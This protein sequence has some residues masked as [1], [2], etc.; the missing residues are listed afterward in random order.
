MGLD[1]RSGQQAHPH[2]RGHADVDVPPAPG[3]SG[4]HHERDQRADHQDRLQ[5]LAEQDEKRLTEERQW[6]QGVSHRALRPLQRRGE[7]GADLPQRRRRGGRAPARLVSDPGKGRL[8]LR[9]QRGVLYS[10]VPLHLL[11]HD[12]PVHRD[13]AGVLSLALLGQGVGRVEQLAH[14]DEDRPI[15]PSAGQ[16]LFRQDHAHRGDPREV[17]PSA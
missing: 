12:V 9:D 5:A 10:Q 15:V 2:R 17:G 3:G 16:G 1:G 7:P 13:R 6:R 4:L 14:P 8:D 11:E